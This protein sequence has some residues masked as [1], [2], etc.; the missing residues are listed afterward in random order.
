MLFSCI[1]VAS[2]LMAFPGAMQTSSCRV[3]AGWSTIFEMRLVVASAV[4]GVWTTRKW[5]GRGHGYLCRY[6]WHW[7][8]LVLCHLV[9]SQQHLNSLKWFQTTPILLHISCPGGMLLI[10]LLV[11]LSF[12]GSKTRSSFWHTNRASPYMRWDRHIDGRSVG[13]VSDATWRYRA[14]CRGRRWKETGELYSWIITLEWMIHK[15]MLMPIQDSWN[16]PSG[17]AY[18]K[19]KISI[20]KCICK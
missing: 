12:F 15:F 6:C 19:I 2:L 17:R 10:W 5:I 4:A 1:Y 7:L 11:W 14:G 3:G 8:L 13:P 18:L 16:F 9:R 20:L